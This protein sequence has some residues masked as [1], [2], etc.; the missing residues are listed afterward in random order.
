M[1]TSAVMGRDDL[2][3]GVKTATLLAINKVMWIQNDLFARHYIP[4]YASKKSP[5]TLGVDERVWPV[6]CGGLATALAFLFNFIN[7]LYW[8]QRSSW[9]RLSFAW[10]QRLMSWWP[11]F[12]RSRGD[13]GRRIICRPICKYMIMIVVDKS[14]G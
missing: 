7:N 9:L 3:Q 14:R 4:S 10:P 11:R 6:V 1:L 12:Y 13:E 2:P 8:P 5:K